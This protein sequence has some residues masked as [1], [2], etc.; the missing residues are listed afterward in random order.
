M[1]TNKRNKPQIVEVAT[2]SDDATLLKVAHTHA[3][4]SYVAGTPLKELG[5][6][7]GAI[8]YMKEHGIV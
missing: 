5:A 7:D 8:E 4:E 3:G 1:G 2:T 6:S